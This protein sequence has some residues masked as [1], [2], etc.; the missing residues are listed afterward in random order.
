VKLFELFGKSRAIYNQN[1]I[2]ITTSS[3]LRKILKLRAETYLNVSSAMTQL[4]R[5]GHPFL[6]YFTMIAATRWNFQSWVVN[7]VHK[8]KSDLVERYQNEDG[9]DDITARK[10]FS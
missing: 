4:S 1:A 5:I 2:G 6:L 10:A 9:W 8:N 3:T 7:S